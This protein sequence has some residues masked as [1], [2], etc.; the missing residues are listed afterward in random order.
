[1]TVFA[2]DILED[3]DLSRAEPGPGYLERLFLR[4]NERVPFETASK[5]LR[6]AS[7]ADPAEKPRFADVF[8]SDRLE[9][10][11][12]GTCFARVAAFG[13]LLDDLGFRSRLALG[14]V[15]KDFDHA[16]L[17][18]ETSSGTV[19]CDVGFPFPALLPAR[20]G[21]VETGLGALAVEE[22]ARGYRI[23]FEDGVPL[24]P[25]QVEV[26]AAAVSGDAFRTHW[27]ATFK[28][29]STF[30]ADVIAQKTLE[31]RRLAF[32][33]GEVRVDDRHSRTR[34]PLAAPRSHALEE[35]F[36]IGAEVLEAAFAIAGDPEP[37]R[38]FSSVDVYLESPVSADE[39]FAAIASPDGYRA[40]LEGVAEVATSTTGPASWTARLLRPE[41]SSAAEIL[42]T[43][44]A[45]AAA[46]TL[47]VRRG[48]QETSYRAEEHEGSPWLVRTGVLEGRRTDLLRN[49][50][51]RGRLAGSLAVDLLGWARRLG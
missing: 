26:F 32:L 24:G 39:A 6:Q 27:E 18:V 22:T 34:I 30:L 15:G 16:A 1:M 25:R 49:D 28:P 17:F 29:T 14:R 46:H 10:G 33:R 7:V 35:I 51:M 13:A 8:W 23:V 44:E 31:N 45:D 42:E 41:G 36:G 37:E 4:F 50:S 9:T 43:V 38:D 20:P 2:D 47:R 48:A 3:L 40:L 19:I 21:R 12:G 11:T 5:I